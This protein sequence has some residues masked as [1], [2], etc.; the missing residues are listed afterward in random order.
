MKRLITPVLWFLCG[1]SATLLAG[2]VSGATHLGELVPRPGEMF[3]AEITTATP[4]PARMTFLTW[5]PD[6]P[7]TPDCVPCCL[8]AEDAEAAGDAGPDG[9]DSEEVNQVDRIEL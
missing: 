1:G 5:H 4:W 9:D 6:T 8:L 2:L 7:D 3:R